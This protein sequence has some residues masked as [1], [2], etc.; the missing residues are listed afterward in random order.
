MN[1]FDDLSEIDKQLESLAEQA[2]ELIQP[3]IYKTSFDLYGQLRQKAK[4]EQR[5]YFY[6][7]SVFH[8]MDEA[9]YLLDF[10][11]MRERAIELISLLESEE[12]CRKIQPDMPP[13][14]YEALVYQMSSCA[15]ENLAEATGQIEGYNSEGM[16]ACIA[17][18]LHV[19]RKTGKLA[20]VG[21][22]REYSCDVYL[23]ADDAEMA[24]HQCSLVLDGSSPLSDRG[25]RRW[26]V[27]KKLASLACL[28][29]RHDEAIKLCREAL[30]LAESEEVTL[31]LEAKIRVLYDLDALLISAGQPAEM[32]SNPAWEHHP[33]EGECPMYDYLKMLNEALALTVSQQYEAAAEILTRWDKKLQDLHGTNLWFEVRLRLIANSLL[34]GQDR[35][36]EKLGKQLQ[37]RASA[38]S[39]WLSLRRLTALQDEDFPTTPLAIY[40]R[41]VATSANGHGDSSSS[42]HDDSELTSDKQGEETSAPDTPLAPVIS[43]FGRRLSE[44]VEEG[45][46]EQLKGLRDE[47]MAIDMDTITHREDACGLVFM[48]SY[49]LGDHA[50]AETVWQWA[51]RLVGKFDDDPAALSLLGD[52]GNRI[53]FGPNEEFGATITSERLDPIFRK[54]LQQDDVGPRTYMRCGDHFMAEDNH[55]EAE[56]CYARGFRLLRNAGDIALRLASLY[57]DTDR[58]RDALH[59]LDLCIREGTEETRVAWEAA[60]LAFSLERF[61]VMLSYLDKY[62]ADAGV[63]PWIDYYRSIGLMEQGDPAGAKAA[64]TRERE[65]IGQDAFHLD[66]ITGCANSQL[67]E[68]AVAAEFLKRASETP[69]YEA[70]MLSPAGISALLHRCEAA[71]RASAPDLVSRFQTRMLQAG[72]ASEEFFAEQREKRDSG[73]V[74]YYRCLV[75]QPLDDSW[76]SFPGRMMHQ[77]DWPAYLGEWGVLAESEEQAEEEVLAAQSL[78]FQL[79]AEFAGMQLIEEGFKDSPGIVWQGIRLSPAEMAAGEEFGDEDDDDYDGDYDDDMDDDDMEDDDM[80]D[81]DDE[82]ADEDD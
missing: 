4:R 78:C 61:E 44:V 59:V 21:C 60:L 33:P 51:N 24:S 45:Y 27:K 2:G 29:G 67:G 49:M 13:Q 43:E 71:A 48:I 41:P 72:C 3:G 12:Q 18:G 38:A 30:E 42:S 74:N 11:T 9:Q 57:R 65:L 68:H 6:I 53:R 52:L 47:V 75:S 28:A 20:C 81:D 16:Q 80:E 39:D 56:R 8:Q 14:L 82:F 50:E 10:Q 32:Q 66:V 36:A 70:D 63:E 58:P 73:Q 1:D 5:A 76:Q 79:P 23:A 17:D 31:P 35:L 15:Y 7:T 64:I 26:L 69:L 19:C 77:E 25:D 46:L 62:Q 55:G 37:K 40:G 54:T 22:F 34:S